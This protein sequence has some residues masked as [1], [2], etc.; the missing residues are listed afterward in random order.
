MKFGDLAKSILNEIYMKTIEMKIV[1]PLVKSSVTGLEGLYGY[2]G[3]HQGGQVLHG[4]GQVQYY[5]QRFHTGGLRGDE[6]MT[7]NKVGKRYITE[8]QNAWLTK[9][10]NSGGGGDI[11]VNIQME[12]KTG[13]PLGIRQTGQKVDEKTKVKSLILELAYSDIEFINGMKGAM[14]R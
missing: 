1:N 10:A 3:F 8:E 12:N 11:K 7:I 5:V 6:R 2:L 9:Q 14:S 4:G 13:L